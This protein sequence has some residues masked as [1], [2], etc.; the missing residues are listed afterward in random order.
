MKIVD[1]I[2]ER[3]KEYYRQDNASDY[4]YLTDGEFSPTHVVDMEKYILK[5]VDFQII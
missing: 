4:S 5:T 3:S 1:Q 2:N